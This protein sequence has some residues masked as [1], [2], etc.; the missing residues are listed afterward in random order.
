[1]EITVEWDDQLTFAG[2]SDKMEKICCAMHQIATVAE[3]HARQMEA[4]ALE[5]ELRGQPLPKLTVRVPRL[6][7]QVYYP[8]NQKYTPRQLQRFA[9]RFQQE[10]HALLEKLELPRRYLEIRFHS[11]PEPLLRLCG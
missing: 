9:D 8:F 1:M 10:V 4:A 11:R 5:V 6:F 2:E 7:I 3:Q